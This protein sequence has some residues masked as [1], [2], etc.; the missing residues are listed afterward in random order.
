MK[1][2]L[3]YLLFPL[4]ILVLIFILYING[5][6]TNEVTSALNLLINV[7]F[8]LVIG[9]MFVISAISFGRLNQFTD[10]LEHAGAEMEKEYREKKENLWEDYRT[11]K[12]PFNNDVLDDAFRKYQKRMAGYQTRRGLTAVCD[13]DEYIN[14]DL[15]DRVAMTHYNSAVSGTLTGLGILGTFLGLS[16]GL[17]S[18]NGNDIY[19]ISDN[20]GPLLE[21]MKV[22]F[23]TSV[24]GIFFSLVFN[25]VY[26][27]LMAGAYDVLAEFQ[28]LYGQCVAPTVSSADE[29]TKA[30]LI[31]QANMS[32]SMKQMTE[33]LKGNAMEQ[34]QAVERIANQFVYLMSQ[35][36][37]A[38]FDKMGR[39]MNVAANMQEQCSR[40][41][42]SMEATARELIAAN[43]SMVQLLE[44]MGKRQEEI[45]VRL[46]QQEA[47]LAD[48]VS[49]L[50][51]ELSNQL[52]TFNQMRDLYEK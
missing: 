43:Q 29:N 25:F 7:G 18:F 8:L 51:E 41:Y 12:N 49:A 21:G 32:N 5:A 40:D 13:L 9:V 47:K 20:V 33:L 26:R 17:G 37:G 24:Y 6:F 10:A 4:Y 31:Y 48:T 28:T 30:M 15:L 46:A 44:E 2:K 34:T 11:R 52:Y 39:S 50:D 38:E 27:S 3:Y 22:A 42:Q 35:S 14:E 36:L 1:K 19:T 45:A 23:H 16:M